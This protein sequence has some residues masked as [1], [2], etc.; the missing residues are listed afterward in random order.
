[1]L[2]YASNYNFYHTCDMYIAFHWGKYWSV[3]GL[4]KNMSTCTVS[5]I[6]GCLQVGM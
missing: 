5:Q 6:I 4:H 1:M 3:V 2:Q